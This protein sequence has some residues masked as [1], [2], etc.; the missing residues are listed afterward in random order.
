MRGPSDRGGTASET[1]YIDRRR[2][3]CF[4][5]VVQ[6]CVMTLQTE[7][8][9][10]LSE[11]A[12]MIERAVGDMDTERFGPIIRGVG[13]IEIR[14]SDGQPWWAVDPDDWN[15]ER[16]NSEDEAVAKATAMSQVDSAKHS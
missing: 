2:E 16:A 4:N 6:T 12:K 10:T 11:E 5:G 13:R 9:V 8:A 3:L 15:Q 14:H 1:R 7:G